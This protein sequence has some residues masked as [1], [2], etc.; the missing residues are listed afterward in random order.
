MDACIGPAFF[1]A[2]EIPLRFFQALEAHP[3]EWGSLRVADARFHFPFAIG[4]LGP[5]RQRYHAVVREHI[6][7]QRVDRG[8]VDVGSRHTFSQVVENHHSRTST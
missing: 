6:A 1:P 3:F 7:E 8:I 4:I 5:A 2:V